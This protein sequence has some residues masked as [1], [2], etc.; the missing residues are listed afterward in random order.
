MPSH[1]AVGVSRASPV[2]NGAEAAL[3]GW[4]L[5]A[6]EVEGFDQ[7]ARCARADLLEKRWANQVELGRPGG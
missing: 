1:S 4:G 3:P 7:G 5:G 2:R 6:D